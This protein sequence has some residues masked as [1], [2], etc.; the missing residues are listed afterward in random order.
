MARDYPD[1]MLWVD[2]SPIQKM[3]YQI[4]GVQSWENVEIPS[5]GYKTFDFQIPNDGYTYVIDTIFTAISKLY[6]YIAYIDICTDYTNPTWTE[7]AA[8][9]F[10]GSGELVLSKAMALGLKYPNALRVGIINTSNLSFYAAIYI[11][12]YKFMEE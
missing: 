3:R 5:M 9:K 12:Y 10:E 6:I 2:R 11:T 8:S 1:G 4:F 7:I